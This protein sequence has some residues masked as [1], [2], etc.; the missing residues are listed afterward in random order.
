MILGKNI[1]FIENG[2]VTPAT[3]VAIDET[4]GLVVK[5]ADGVEK[6][7]KSGEISIRW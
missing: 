6:T 2:K 3:A 5:T 7:L 1:N 4:G